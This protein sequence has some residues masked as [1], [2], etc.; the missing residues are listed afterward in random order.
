MGNKEELYHHLKSSKNLRPPRAGRRHKE[1]SL[2]KAKEVTH[3]PACC[4]V[5]ITYLY[6]TIII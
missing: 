1:E 3:Q 2:E 4:F 6:H 5:N